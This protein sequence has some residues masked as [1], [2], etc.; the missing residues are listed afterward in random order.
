MSIRH[1]YVANIAEGG[2]EGAIVTYRLGGKGRDKS[3]APQAGCPVIRTSKP[4][5]HNLSISS[6]DRILLVTHS[7]AASSVVG[8]WNVGP[9]GCVVAGSERL[10]ETGGNPFGVCFLR[11][12][13][14]PRRG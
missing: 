3:W 13:T 7:G 2:K 10:V 12:L 11:A 5:P 14:A 6:D 4:T 9:D 8:L 1:G